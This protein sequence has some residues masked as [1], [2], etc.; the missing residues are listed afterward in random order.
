MCLEKLNHIQKETEQWVQVYA[1]DTWACINSEAEAMLQALHSRSTWW[2]KAHLKVLAEKWAEEFMW[3]F[4]VWYG[5][6]SIWDCGSM[7]LFIEWLSM[8]WAKAIQDSKLYNGQEASTR[9]IDFSKQKILNLAWNKLWEEIQEQQRNFYLSILEPLKKH[10]EQKFPMQE[11][12]KEV[13]YKKAISAKA[14]DIA[15]WFL[16]AWTTTNLAWHSNL[17]QIADR[18][19]QLRH[20]PLAEVRQIA[21]TVLDTVNEKYP[22][23]FSH[24]TYEETEEYLDFVNKKYYYFDENIK[25]LIL[26]QDSIDKQELDNYKDIFENRPNEKTELPSFLNNIWTMKFR[27]LLDFWSFRDI[28][29]HRAINQ[30]MPLLTDRQW[31]NEFYIQNLPEEL[32]EKAIQHL[33][34]IR[35]KIDSLNLSKEERQYY[36]PMWY[37]ISNEVLWT[38]PALIYMIELRSTRFVHP[39]L[40]KIAH[41]IWNI[42]KEKHNIKLFLDESWIEFD[43]KRWEQ[44]IVMK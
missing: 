44:D 24:K 17:R 29:R 6:K 8:L 9:Y 36:I 13:I 10:L 19:L 7:T 31:F 39:T 4:Y 22:N 40:R 23:S 26:V 5:H 20:H 33:Q 35:Q 11:W 25:D 42:L 21:S 28:Q 43:S 18:V 1:L 12:E 32:Q 38:L 16:P 15:R 30:R 2:I 3:K 34:D 14:F 27:F 41:E 37:N